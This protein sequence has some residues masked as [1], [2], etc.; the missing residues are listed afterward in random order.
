MNTEKCDDC[1]LTWPAGEHGGE[2][3]LSAKDAEIARLRKAVVFA[4][5]SD[6]EILI[7]DFHEGRI[8]WTDR[9]GVRRFE[10]WDGTDGSLIETLCRLAQQEGE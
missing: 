9:D 10:R 1:G 3:C 6:M 5:Q 7:P 2:V 4:V 8:R